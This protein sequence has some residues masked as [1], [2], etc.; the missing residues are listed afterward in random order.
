MRIIKE[1][2]PSCLLCLMVATGDAA[3]VSLEAPDLDALAGTTA[4][5]SPELAGI[6]L[7]DVIRPF[8]IEWGAGL[9]MTGTIQDRV[10]RSD[11]DN[12]LIF[13]YRIIND[14]TSDAPLRFVMREDYAGFTTDVDWRSDGLGVT[15]PNFATRSFDGSDVTFFFNGL[16]MID[17]G[18]DSNF[19][20]IKT[21]ATTYNEDGSGVIAVTGSE[22]NGRSFHFDTFQPL[23]A[24][25][26]VP[27]PSA[28][29]MFVSGLMGLMLVKRR[30]NVTT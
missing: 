4:A 26:A 10:V 25:T 29:Y 14:A 15:G 20:F 8:T 23:E 5:A 3:A 30:S 9:S 16:A 13:S 21:N 7:E 24:V 28:L 19:F 2:L 17:P 6:V 22:N 11:V 12:T 27:L 1:A 18:E